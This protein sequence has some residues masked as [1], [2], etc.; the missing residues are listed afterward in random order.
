MKMKALTLI[1]L[2]FGTWTNV[3]ASNDG[4]FG[5][6]NIIDSSADS[7]SAVL[8]ADLDGDGDLDVVSTSAGDHSVS[9]YDNTDGLGTFGTKQIIS[10]SMNRAIVVHAADLDGDGDLDIISASQSDES[11]VWFENTTGNGDFGPPITITTAS[12]ITESVYAADIDGDGDLDVVS[13][14]SGNRSHKVS[15]YENVN[16]LG[17]FGGQKNLIPSNL[18]GVDSARAGDLDGDGDLDIIYGT[19]DQVV[20]LRNTNAM[21][22]FSS[23]ILMATGIF[24]SKEIRL[25]DIDNDGDLD[26]LFSSTLI[27]GDR[28]SIMWYKNDGA[29]NFVAQPLIDNGDLNGA[30]SVDYA[31]FDKDGDMDVVSASRTDNTVIWFEN[32]D[33]QGSFGSQ[34]IISGTVS[35]TIFVSVADIDGDG[36]DD[37]LSASDA[38]DKIA[39]YENNNVIIDLIFADSFD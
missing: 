34:Q 17:S 6:Q 16:G 28:I 29:G 20:W 2:I 21:G 38:D 11:I 9:W 15:W 5:N 27:T 39:W 12:Q 14:S 33:G 24:G 8:A 7:A 30:W 32:V 35:G 18:R 19:I 25:V 13:G 1:M 36:D 23:R 26:V 31:D 22:A 10:G 3:Y 37:V 4:Q